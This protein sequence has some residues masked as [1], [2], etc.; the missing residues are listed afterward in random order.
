MWHGV[1]AMTTSQFTE[2]AK[3]VLMQ[4]LLGR[5]NK[6]HAIEGL[7]LFS[8]F[9]AL[10]LGLG[11]VAFELPQ[12][13]EYGYA[14]LAAHPAIFIGQAALGFAVNLLTITTVKYTSS[15]SFKLISMAKNAAIVLLSVPVFGNPISPT[16]ALGYS[17]TVLGFGSCARRALPPPEPR[18]AG[19]ACPPPRGSPPRAAADN[20]AK[21]FDVSRPADH[22][23]EEVRAADGKMIA[24][25]HLA[26][27]SR[28][29]PMYLPLS[30]RCAWPT[31]SSNRRPSA[32]RAPRPPRG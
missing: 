10:S 1:L 4:L 32:R 22:R 25:E 7:L 29:L 11:V 12:L 9:A 16:Q 26:L 31:A 3:L 17:V 19:P 5:K 28:D 13:R 30:P 21:L 15:I 2:A 18:D 23:Y 20:Y 27:I 24:L 14:I 8:P 6:M